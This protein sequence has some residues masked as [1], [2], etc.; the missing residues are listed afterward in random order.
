MYKILFDE[1]HCVK[2]L[3]KPKFPG[4][5]ILAHGNSPEISTKKGSLLSFAFHIKEN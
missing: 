2:Y 3:Q 4:P 1:K 5:R